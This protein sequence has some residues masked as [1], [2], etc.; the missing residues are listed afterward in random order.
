MRVGVV[1]PTYGRFGDAAAVMRLVH[2]AEDLGYDGAWFADH[3]AIP[4]YAAQWVPP[5][6]LDPL[7]V[8]GVGLGATTTLRFGTDVLVAPY[9]H[10]LALAASLRSLSALG[11][12]RLTIGI[13]VGYLEGEFAAL[14]VDAST[15]GVRT[16]ETLQ[17][18]RAARTGGTIDHEGSHFSFH[19][20]LPGGVGS[21]PPLWVGGNAAVARRRAAELGD[22]W[23][24]LWIPPSEY[25]EARVE[26]EQHRRA[27]GLTS[28]FTFSM[29]CPRGAVEDAPRDWSSVANPPPTPTRAEFQYVPPLPRTR[30]GRPRFTGTPDEL[31]A[32]LDA[33]SE[34]GVDHLVV[35]FWTSAV[36]LD[37]SGLVHQLKRFAHEVLDV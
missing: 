26:I 20:V 21:G 25:A 12:D 35:R 37:E 3:L 6:V 14:G 10:P 30:E 19:D 32:D 5:P 28:P 7:A 29:S 31:R 13:G 15:R 11:G 16:D 18:L 17:V 34:V 33:Y 36:D 8:C 24:P 9:R 2:V 4:Q 1:V 27:K 23:H 22:G